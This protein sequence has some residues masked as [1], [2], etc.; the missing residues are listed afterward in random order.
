[1]GKKKNTKKSNWLN[2]KYNKPKFECI[3]C[4]KLTN[5]SICGLCSKCWEGE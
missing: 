4:K 2:K 1:M 5:I 3:K